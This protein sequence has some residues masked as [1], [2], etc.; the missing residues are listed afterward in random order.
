MESEF[1]KKYGIIYAFP[2]ARFVYRKL[3]KP[4]FNFMVE[5]D[6]L[7]KYNSAGLI[8]EK[9]CD[10]MNDPE[11]INAFNARLR[12]TP[13]WKSAQWVL[14]VNMWAVDYAKKLEGDFVE[15]GVYKGSLAMF[16][17]TY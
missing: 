10:F 8:T 6:P 7:Y 14:Y 11:F 3:V 16:N 17:L 2:F 1:K 9:N 15:C 4:L 5:I 12:Q 13:T